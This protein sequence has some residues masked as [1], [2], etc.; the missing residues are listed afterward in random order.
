MLII[1]NILH[2]HAILETTFWNTE[3]SSRLQLNPHCFKPIRAD[4]RII[5]YT[6]SPRFWQMNAFLLSCVHEVSLIFFPSMI[7]QSWLLFGRPP[8]HVWFTSGDKVL[9][10][11]HLKRTPWSRFS[12]IHTAN[13]PLNLSTWEKWSNTPYTLYFNLASIRISLATWRRH[14]PN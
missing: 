1:P 14:Y 2:I 9:P 10:E 6:C 8:L 13:P 4:K 7:T 11:C 12:P 5:F 3:F